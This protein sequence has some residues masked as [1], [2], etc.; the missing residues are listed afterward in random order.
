MCF[1]S[2]VVALPP[3]SSPPRATPLCISL[4][5]VEL[6]AFM[7]FPCLECKSSGESFRQYDPIISSD[8]SR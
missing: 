5:N 1:V 8:S 4:W 2:S 3:F 6:N 7:S